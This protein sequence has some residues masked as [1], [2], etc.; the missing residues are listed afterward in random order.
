MDEL[1]TPEKMIG[2]LDKNLPLRR[3][4]F[5]PLQLLQ[6]CQIRGLDAYAKLSV[7]KRPFNPQMQFGLVIVGVVPVD[8]GFEN[9]MICVKF[10]LSA[11]GLQNHVKDSY[12]R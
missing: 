3:R 4:C 7:L 10:G 2:L 5:Q 11:W 8:L 1:W 9:S 6:M 12:R